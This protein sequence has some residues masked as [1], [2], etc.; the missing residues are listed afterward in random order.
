[1]PGARVNTVGWI[2]AIQAELV[3]ARSFLDEEHEPPQNPDQN[4]NNVYTLGS[5]GRH[6]VV[7]AI[8]SKGGIRNKDSG[9]AFLS[10]TV[11]D[12]VLIHDDHLVLNFFFDFGDA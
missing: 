9:K 11:L 8:L 6:N 2:S 3:A 10:T 1:M 4:D 7:M 12:H 5:I